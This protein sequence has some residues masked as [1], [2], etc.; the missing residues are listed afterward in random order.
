MAVSE[1]LCSGTEFID[2][3]ACTLSC[4]PEINNHA[5]YGSDQIGSDKQDLDPILTFH[6]LVFRSFFVPDHLPLAWFLR[7]RNEPDR[8]FGSPL[9][10]Q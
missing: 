6:D 5:F 8:C 7:S 1:A 2:G 10:S 4:C 3:K 9:Q